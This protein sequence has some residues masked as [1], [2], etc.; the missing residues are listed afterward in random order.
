M[1]Q[2]LKLFCSCSARA[3]RHAD[4]PCADDDLIRT[5][6]ATLGGPIIKNKLFF[7][8]NFEMNDQPGQAIRTNG[9][10]KGKHNFQLSVSIDNIGNMINSS[11]GVTRW[12][13]YTTSNGTFTNPV[14]KLSAVEDGTPVFS[15]NKVGDSYPTQTWNKYYK[16][17]SECWQLLFGLKYYFN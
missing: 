9:I 2:T 13:C 5:I 11:W 1:K 8:T 12:S 15:M 17:P 3:F 7:F 10:G 14:L 4:A 16:N 6:G